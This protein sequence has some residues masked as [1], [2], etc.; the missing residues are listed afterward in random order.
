MEM[1][2]VTNRPSSDPL[3]STQALADRLGAPDLRIIDASYRSQAGV[4]SPPPWWRDVVDPRADFAAGRLP[5]AVYLDIDAV[6][7]ADSALPHMLASPEVFA[8]VVS[9]LGVS[10]DDDIVVY[11]NSGLF[12]AA[13]AWWMLRVMGARRVRVLDGGGPKWRAEGRPLE[14]GPARV[15]TPARFTPDFRAADVVGIE[16][17][18]RALA[19]GDQVVDARSRARFTGQAPEPRP[20]LRSGRMPGALSLPFPGIMDDSGVMKRGAD[21]QAVL[22]AAG[23]DLARPVITTCGSGVTAANLN[24]ALAVLGRPSRLYDGSWTEWGGRADTPVE[25]G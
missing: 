19:A 9:G 22:E 1:T 25:T 6:S 12:S 5:G 14:T 2:R 13:R 16:E 23:V 24:L 4:A 17:V 21:L 3:I 11:D 15:P 20:G 7:D 8:R 18:R 10:Q